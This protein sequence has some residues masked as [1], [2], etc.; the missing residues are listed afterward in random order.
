[1]LLLYFFPGLKIKWTADGLKMIDIRQSPDT[2]E[3]GHGCESALPSP[4]SSES[5][6]HMTVSTTTV[7]K[8]PSSRVHMEHVP[9]HHPS[10]DTTSLLAMSSQEPTSSGKYTFT[11]FRYL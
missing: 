4:H 2:V 8:S 9:H 5:D 7:T 1:M 10:I 11:Y 3:R 6:H